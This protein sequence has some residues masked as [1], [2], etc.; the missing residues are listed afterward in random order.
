MC[1]PGYASLGILIERVCLVLDNSHQMIQGT[2]TLLDSS[3]V[4]N[5]NMTG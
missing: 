5:N 1:V 2:T 3:C 4:E